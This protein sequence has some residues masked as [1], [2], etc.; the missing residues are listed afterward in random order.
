VIILA[1]NFFYRAKASKD[2]QN[3]HSRTN[4]KQKEDTKGR[5]STPGVSNT[6]PAKTV[7]AARVT[8]NIKK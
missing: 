2:C 4:F 1:D 3:A 5:Y 7:H 8:I 6:R